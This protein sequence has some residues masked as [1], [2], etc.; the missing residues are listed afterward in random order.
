MVEQYPGRADALRLVG[1]RLL[2]LKQPAPAARLFRQVEQARPFEAHSYRDLA[3]SLEE[4]GKY[5]LAAV[6]Y[7]IV[8]AGTW[9]NRF[10]HALKTVAA[11][12]LLALAGRSP[13]SI[14]SC[15]GGIATIG[16][17]VKRV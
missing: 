2:D 11:A 16:A 14:S 7:E 13:A 3:R 10:S 4:C 17:C 1:Y 15:I 6:H 5:G 8:L 12:L 9:D